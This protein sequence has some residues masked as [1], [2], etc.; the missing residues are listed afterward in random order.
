M[1]ELDLA[2]NNLIYKV[3]T[4]SS[5]TDMSGITAIANV[6]PDM[7][8]LVGTIKQLN[9]AR[10]LNGTT[11]IVTSTQLPDD[12]L[13]VIK[14]HSGR[15]WVISRDNLHLQG[16]TNGA[17]TSLNLPSN[18]LKAEGGKIVAEAITVPGYLT[19]RWRSFWQHFHAHLSDHW[20]NCCCLLLSMIGSEGA[21]HVAEAIKVCCCGCFDTSSMLHLTN[22]L[23]A[24]VCR[25]P[26]DMRALQCTDGTSYQP[27]TSVMMSTHMCRHFGQHKTQHTSR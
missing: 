26:Q 24:V 19:I 2:G 12:S 13:R 17:L 16:R 22:G 3:G 18:N 5:E 1:K 25:C 8:V 9:I 7:G 6:I 27:K 10:H 4:T 21:K 14:L 20:L 11:C 15:Q 23:T